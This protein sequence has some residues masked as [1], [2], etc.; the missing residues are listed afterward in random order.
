[1]INAA[2]NKGGN[3]GELELTASNLLKKSKEEK[4]EQAVIGSDRQ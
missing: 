1:V 4:E 3:Q 2:M